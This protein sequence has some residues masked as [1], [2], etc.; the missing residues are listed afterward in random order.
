MDSYY[1]MQA[2]QQIF[3]LSIMTS[4]MFK[5]QTLQ[6]TYSGT[7]STQQETYTIEQKEQNQTEYS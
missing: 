1:L 6:P 5:N 7:T 2:H 4:Q 3:T